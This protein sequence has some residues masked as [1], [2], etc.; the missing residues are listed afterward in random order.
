MRRPFGP[1]LLAWYGANARV[2]PW[3]APPGGVAADPY[4]VWL[5]EVML[6][7][8][9]VA[10]AGPRF[11]RFLARFP[12]VSALAEAA[13]AEVMGE[14]AGLGYY[15][16][17][18]NLH[19]AARIVAAAG[20]FPADEPG[21]RALPGVGDYTAAAVAA[22]ALGLRTVPVDGN[23]ARVGARLFAADLAPP[24]LSARLAGELGDRPGD[25]AQALM[26]V[27]SAICTPT[28]P[29]CPACPLA[30]ACLAR[31][32]GTPTAWPTRRVRPLKPARAGVVFWLRVGDEVL[33]VRRPPHGLLGGMAA[34]PSSAWIEGTPPDPLAEAPAYAAW[35]LLP[36][37]A[38]QVFTHFTLTLGVAVAEAAVRPVPGDWV[39]ADRLGHLPAVFAKAAAIARRAGC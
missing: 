18:R 23:I 13:D 20:A 31:A 30:D 36:T 35:R 28:S 1:A 26:D 6:Q 27:G 16:R 8:T 39:A 19:A 21:W 9:T 38:R 32:A 11:E 5:S 34:L 3:R 2:L 24:Q 29:D 4:R 22:I 25:F 14:W 7:Q 33:T 12:S 17:A 10:A 15:A 37:P